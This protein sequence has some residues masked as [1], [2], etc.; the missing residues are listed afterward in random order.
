MDDVH[1]VG[2][3]H[4]QKI[5]VVDDA[6]A[7]VGGLDLT[8]KRWDTSTPGPGDKRR[9]TP[10]A[11]Y[12]PPH[13][14]VQMMVSGKIA[15]DLG[16]FF[17]Q[18]WKL[19]NSENLDAGLNR[20]SPDIW[21]EAVALDIL[22]GKVGIARTRAAYEELEAVHEV[23][24]L[25]LDSIRWAARYIYIEN[26]YLTSPK[27][28]RV[29]AES[30]RKENGPE[31]IIVLPLSTEGWLSQHTIDVLRYRAVSEMMASDRYQRLGIFYAHQE[32]LP[33]SIK[34][35]AKLM[36]ADDV[37]VRIGSANLNNRSMGL[38]T[39]C[40]L[41]MEVAEDSARQKGIAVFCNKLLAE[42]LGVAA[43]EVG[44][45]RNATGSM[46]Q[47]IT[48]L[49][50]RRRTLRK[51][52][53]RQL[54][55]AM[56]LFAGQQYI[57]DPEMPMQPER[58]LE[59]L[60]PVEELEK[61]NYDQ[62]GL[63]VFILAGFGLALAWR[64]TP[65]DELISGEHLR[66]M[67]NF[68]KTTD[69]AWFYACGGF[70]LG[71]F[72]FIPILVLITVTI[73][74]YGAYEG[75]LLV[76]ISSCASGAV[77]YWLGRLLGRRT[78]RKLAGGKVNRLSIRLGKSG[79]LSTFIVRLV[80]IAPY[81]IINIFAGATHIRFRDFILG[82][83]LGLLPSSLAIAGIIDRGSALFSNPGPATILGLIAVI[84]VAAGAYFFMHRKLQ[85]EK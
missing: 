73:L 82:T 20:D 85:E 68:L 61:K 55:G 11:G 1:P 37:F 12:Y 22:N 64:F 10:D 47:T 79:F 42:H 80:P 36:I 7:F 49:Q 34:I 70:I 18:R 40:D 39:E 63:L 14:D 26:Q 58:L 9:K 60:L 27:I 4:H 65:L 45:T 32:G 21:P 29:L 31:I 43:G 59:Q 48:Q 51:L 23:E 74:I 13:H 77:T 78:V 54:E 25:Y 15:A 16:E 84:A 30:L 66:R 35:H 67:V 2:A 8:E 72:L 33:D 75:P 17:R 81:S 3:S 62:I 38:D 83:A 41:A 53:P 56:E 76:L 57:Y 71:T 5:V 44:R 46:L 24:K 69:F 50:G 6:V 28:S 19:V 52:D